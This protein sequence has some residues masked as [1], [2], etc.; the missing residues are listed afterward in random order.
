MK[1]S[2]QE[3]EKI[4]FFFSDKPVKK[5]FLFGSFARGEAD[6]NSDVD[7]LIDWDYTQHI[8]LNYIAWLFEIKDLLRKEVDFVSWEFISPLIEKQIHNDKN[9][10][11]EA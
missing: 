11:Y 2:P 1:L 5:V 7:L 6:E 10:I 3:I 4:R 9:L 8:G